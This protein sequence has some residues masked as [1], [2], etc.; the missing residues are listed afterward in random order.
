MV[1]LDMQHNKGS[2]QSEN[3]PL[4]SPAGTFAFSP[5]IVSLL[6]GNE[7]C[8]CVLCSIDATAGKGGSAKDTPLMSSTLKAQARARERARA[9]TK[10][11]PT[12]KKL[13]RRHKS[14]SP[15]GLSSPLR[16]RLRFVFVFVFFQKTPVF[17]SRCTCGGPH[18]VLAARGDGKL[19]LN[20]RVFSGPGL[21]LDGGAAARAPRTRC[22]RRPSA[23]PSWD[24]TTLQIGHGG[25]GQEEGRGGGRSACLP[26]NL[27][28]RSV[29]GR[30]GLSAFFVRAL[31]VAPAGEKKTCNTTRKDVSAGVFQASSAAL[32]KPTFGP[33]CLHRRC[34]GRSERA[35]AHGVALA[36]NRQPGGGR[37]RGARHREQGARS[38]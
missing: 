15:A 36:L 26:Y 32:M 33:C 6:V 35:H 18:T 28:A 12:R 13:R 27:T 19:C 24:E 7:C 2:M 37:R 30:V 22:P 9:R 4:V 3:L 10:K 20:P 14:L 17:Y 31:N 8:C 16:F 38:Y 25:E 21:R 5:D 11:T 1:L 23:A 34:R 29:K